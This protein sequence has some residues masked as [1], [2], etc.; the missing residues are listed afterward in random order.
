MIELFNLINKAKKIG[1]KVEAPVRKEDFILGY[2]A[3]MQQF[4]TKR[5]KNVDKAESK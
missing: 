2:Y 5:E 3:Q 1:E 4:F